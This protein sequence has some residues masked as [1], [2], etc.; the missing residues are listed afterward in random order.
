MAMRLTFSF[1]ILVAAFGAVGCTSQYQVRDIENASLLASR[2]E[3]LTP[4][5]H[6]LVI[7]CKGEACKAVTAPGHG[8]AYVQATTL[9]PTVT[10]LAPGLAAQQAAVKPGW[11]VFAGWMFN[12]RGQPEYS[13]N[14]RV[15]RTPF[16]N[17]VVAPPRPMCWDYSPTLNQHVW[18]G[19]CGPFPPQPF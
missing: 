1:V 19:Q 18:T 13:L 17:Q 12:E 7:G 8:S 3:R 10:A 11:Y 15:I 2:Y 16:G 5:T 4:T 14:T 6:E 9:P